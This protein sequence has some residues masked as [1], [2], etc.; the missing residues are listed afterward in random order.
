VHRISGNRKELGDLLPCHNSSSSMLHSLF[1][2]LFCTGA[3]FMRSNTDLAALAVIVITCSISTLLCV[4][5]FAT[6][7]YSGPVYLNYKVLQEIPAISQ[8]FLTLRS[9]SF[10]NVRAAF[11]FFLST[12]FGLS[13]FPPALERLTVRLLCAWDDVPFELCQRCEDMEDE[14]SAGSSGPANF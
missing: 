3:F 2:L 12:P 1:S 11:F 9:G 13:P 7:L 14:L 5:S 6:F 8:I 10:F 4:F